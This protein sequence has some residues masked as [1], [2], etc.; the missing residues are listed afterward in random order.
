MHH[1]KSMIKVV[2]D[3]LF[4]TVALKSD[5]PNNSD[6]DYVYAANNDLFSTYNVYRYR[7]T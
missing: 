2:H 7:A 3:V 1:F 6:S 4:D 5:K